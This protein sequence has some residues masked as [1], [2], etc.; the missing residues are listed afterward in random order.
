MDRA[1]G[2]AIT[3]A[4]A[5]T[6]LRARALVLGLPAARDQHRRLFE[7]ADLGDGVVARPRDDERRVREQRVDVGRGAHDREARDALGVRRRDAVGTDDEDR[8]ERGKADAREE[9]GVRDG[10]HVAARVD[11]LPSA[12][13]HGDDERAAPRALRRRRGGRGAQRTHDGA[14]ERDRRARERPE[15]DLARLVRHDDAIELERPIFRDE[16]LERLAL[17]LAQNEHRAGAEGGE[18][19]HDAHGR[20]RVEDDEVGGE[21]LQR[22]DEGRLLEGVRQGG[23]RALGIGVRLRQAG[24]QA[25]VV[26]PG[27]LEQRRI[28]RVR[29]HEQADARRERAHLGREAHA[30]HDV[31]E[32]DAIDRVEC[33]AELTGFGHGA[34]PRGSAKCIAAGCY[35][36]RLMRQRSMGSRRRT[37]AGG[38]WAW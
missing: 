12:A 32:T 38:A 27:T 4:P 14:D 24:R 16:G 30:P 23:H 8:L 31:A 28:G 26:E 33:N 7:R 25:H 19:A 1:S 18:L 29:E 15:I 5:R 3:A 6:S 34:S 20:V 22:R 9:M 36:P 2:F 17:E 13:R 10:A 35:R 21:R 37:N 11:R